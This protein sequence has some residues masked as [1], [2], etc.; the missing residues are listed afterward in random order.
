[1]KAVVYEKFGSTDVLNVREIEKPT[2]RDNE[3]L[4]KVHAAS[5]NSW[6]WDLLR[7]KPFLTRLDG[8]LLKPKFKILGADISGK[9]E[10]IGSKVK[11][12]QI[13]NEVFGDLSGCRWGGFAEY[14][15]A[16]ENVL[17]LKP[18][19]MPYDEAASIPQA[20]VLALQ[21]LHYGGK[22][23]KGQKIL[24]NGAGGGVGT[25]AIQMAKSFGAEVTAVDKAEKRDIMLAVGAD[26]VIDYIQENFTQ[27]G[28]RYDLILDVIATRSILDYVRI[29]DSKGTY[30]MVGGSTARILQLALL[31][32]LISRITAKKMGILIHKPNKQDLNDINGLYESGS[33]KPII[34]K[35][36]PLHEVADALRYYGE[37]QTRGKIVITMEQ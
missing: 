8:G 34:D 13:G 19:H 25:F 6:D 23:Q 14:V 1:M 16:D 9:I 15:C 7:G 28:Q 26:H 18:A 32:P 20:A 21:G 37:G 4:I 27:H 24:I 31:G 3:V 11:Q 33:I 17:A 30:V 35:H 29:L 10:A 36:F 22:I 5:I 2:P 12:L